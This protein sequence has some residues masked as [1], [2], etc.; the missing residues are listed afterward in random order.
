[1]YELIDNFLNDEEFKSIESM[2]LS[3]EFPWYLNRVIDKKSYEDNLQFTHTVYSKDHIQS[4]WFS[5]FNC[6][7]ERMNIFTPLRVKAN[8][9]SQTEKRVVH[10]FHVDIESSNAP[11]NINTSIFY[12]NSNNGVTIFEDTKEEVES[13]SNRMI[14][15]PGYLKHHVPKNRYSKSRITLSGNLNVEM[16]K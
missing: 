9:L 2:L 15:F 7:F 8:Y 14:I 10:D 12:L 6:F 5:A 4:N 1:M 3:N 13:V 11:K 16:E